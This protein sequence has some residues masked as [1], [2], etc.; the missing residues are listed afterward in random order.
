MRSLMTWRV[1][2]LGIRAV[3]VTLLCILL[4]ILA[5]YFMRRLFPGLWGGSHP[6]RTRGHGASRDGS[7]KRKHKGHDGE[8][9]MDNSLPTLLL[10]LG[11]PGSGKTT[12]VNQYVERCDRSFVVV[13]EDSIQ[14]NVAAD[15][16]DPSWETQVREAMLGDI[17]RRLKEKQNV[18]VD[19]C[20][21]VM[22]EDFRRGIIETAPA[23]RLLVKHF[24]IKA[25]Y[26]H[27]RLSRDAEE[28][29]G[30]RCLTEIE[31]EELE[32]AFDKAR[33]SMKLEGWKPLLS[34]VHSRS[35][36]V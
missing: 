27:A 21:R 6:R 7:S 20:L 28:A 3:V 22:D 4:N 2:P 35:K 19:D 30:R 34:V 9:R 1:G 17:V 11:I 29:N 32:M 14:G 31:L 10:L 25:F 8:G 23:C 36:H 15:K 16:N 26:A 33:A 5:L 24:P 18:V 13:R 12:W